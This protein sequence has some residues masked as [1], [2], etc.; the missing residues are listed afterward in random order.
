MV[1]LVDAEDSKSSGLYALE[2]SS[3]S[4]GTSTV[5]RGFD[6]LKV[7]FQPLMPDILFT[8]YDVYELSSGSSSNYNN[9]GSNSN[10][11][12]NLKTLVLFFPKYLLNQRTINILMYKTRNKC[13]IWYPLFNSLY[14]Y[15]IIIFLCQ[16]KINT[17]IFL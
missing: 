16:T 6:N 14:L 8:I 10:A 17:L 9:G 5:H 12:S 1:E 13:L 7:L 3:L 15:L 2:S 11:G 4:S